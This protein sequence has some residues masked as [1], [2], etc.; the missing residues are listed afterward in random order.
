[1]MT[2]TITDSPQ[3]KMF[4]PNEKMCQLKNLIL[5]LAYTYLVFDLIAAT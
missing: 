2:V 4:G 3:M 5:K 1:M